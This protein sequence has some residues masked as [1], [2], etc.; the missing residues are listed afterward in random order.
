MCRIFDSLMCI[1]EEKS[2]NGCNIKR[3]DI[4][5]VHQLLAFT[6]LAICDHGLSSEDGRFRDA[7][8]ATE[9]VSKGIIPV[10]L[11]LM[12]PGKDLEHI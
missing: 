11:K 4:G 2:R 1:I 9:M 3:Q 5:N 6:Y 7:N 10:I 8:F 12:A